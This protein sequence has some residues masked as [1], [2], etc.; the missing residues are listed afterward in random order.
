M[1]EVELTAIVKNRTEVLKKLA[2]HAIKPAHDVIYDDLYFDKN[3]ELDQ[4]NCE[5]RIRKKT[6]PLSGKTTNWLTLK[7]APFDQ[8]T[9]SKP[10]FETE[11]SNFNETKAIVEGLGY[12]LKIRYTKNCLFYYATYK[13]VELEISVVELPELTETFIEIET[14]TEELNQTDALFK[15]LYNFLDELGMNENDLTTTQYQDAMRESRRK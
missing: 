4:R 6:F 13:N 1:Y 2:K 5:L 7:E 14:Q 15:V 12:T 3:N 10:E 9:R 11:I 8:K